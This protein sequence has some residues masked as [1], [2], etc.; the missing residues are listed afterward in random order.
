MLK[1]KH[2]VLAAIVA[3]S[4]SAGNANALVIDLSYDPAQFADAKGVQALA[5]FQE[6]ANFWGSVFL[7][8]TTVNLGIG[9]SELDPGVIGS[10]GSNEDGY[11]YNDVALAMFGDASSAFDD[12]ANASLPCEDQGNGLCNFSF[13]DQENPSAPVSPEYDNDGT[14]DNALLSLTQANAKALGLGEGI[15]GWEV[16]DAEITFSSTFDFDFDR[17]DG[18]S[19]GMMDFVGVAIH[20]I[21]HALGFVSSV[22]TYDIVYNSGLI[23][24]ELDLDGYVLAS[25]LDLFR[26]SADSVAVGAGVRDLDPGSDAYFSLDGGLTPLVPFSTGRFGGDG[27]QASHFKDNLDIGIMD[28][29]LAYGE[30]ADVTPWDLLAFDVIGWDVAVAKVPAPA[31]I[32]LLGLGL[33]GLMVRRKKQ[34]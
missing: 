19:A 32:G 8:D 23:D 22:D 24:P 29:T 10:T 17:T 33:A 9:F 25:A 1:I 7:D 30:F 20:E 27:N 15:F 16:L 21:G 4:L 13:L 2:S 3:G 18:I 26:Y 6:A 34:K 31:S 14:A 12:M 5:G 11:Y 28:P